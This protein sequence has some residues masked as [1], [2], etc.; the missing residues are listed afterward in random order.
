MNRIRPGGAALF[1]I[2]SLFA[3]CGKQPPSTPP[4]P[5]VKDPPPATGHPA[6]SR[7]GLRFREVGLEAGLRYTWSIPGKRPLNI[8]QTIGNGC[9]FQD[10]DGD[11]NL[12]ILLVGPKLALYRGDG[13]GH[14]T[15]VTHATGL[16]AVH[17][18]F[19]GC[20]VGDYDNDGFDDLYISGYHTGV[21]L[22]N[23][24]GKSFKDVSA[25]A[26]IGPLP[27]GSS[28]GFADLDGDGYLD[29]Y[30]ANYVKF[31]PTVDLLL[32]PFKGV[33]SGCGPVNYDAAHGVLYHN[34]GGR[35]F[36]DMTK[37]AGALGQG[38]GL[39]VAFA[40]YRYDGR[41]SFA[42]ANDLMPG[43]LFQS[44]GSGKFKNVGLESGTA[45]DDAGENH[46][47]MGIDWADYDNDGG[48]D[49]F[50]T[51]FANEVKTLYHNDGHGV[52]S[53]ASAKTKLDDPTRPYVAWG[54]KFF[55]ADNDGWLDLLIAN[56][57]VQ[58]NIGQFEKQTYRE[59]LVFLH[60]S[61][62]A[63]VTFEDMTR[64]SGIVQVGKLVGRGLAIGDYDN[65]G[66]VDALV[67]DSEGRPRL[68][69]NESETGANW[70]GFDLKGKGPGN[71]DGYGAVIRVVTNG[72][73]RFRQCQPG[74]SYLSSS[75]PRVHF[76]LGGGKPDIV[77][78]W[79]HDGWVR[80]WTDLAPGRYYTLQ[81][82]GVE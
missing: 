44:V 77:T 10:Y 28:C 65:D 4:S 67:V 69:H 21:L 33:M 12:D 70:I 8:L 35:R 32:C 58:D 66:R 7:P 38:K 57:H 18:H 37:S 55:D 30:V 26:G 17:G 27:W 40:K 72:Q 20:A 59:P 62:K 52:F 23:E 16:D 74:G 5:Q 82:L 60:N 1:F 64:S 61:G 48:I 81:D 47:G 56:G 36:T 43:D 79:W 51:T 76:G 73:K 50:V 68:L 75:D 14:F 15:D 54:C 46:A 3:A 29:L 39:G 78:I 25:A 49:L 80:S 63:P 6:G 19:L 41:L 71:R 2:L 42:V 24:G 22:H 45:G 53:I 11:G 9:A 34:E 31:D 13:K